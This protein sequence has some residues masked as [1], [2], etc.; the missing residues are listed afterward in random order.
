MV[1]RAGGFSV[2]HSCQRA[3]VAV[4]HS[5]VRYHQAIVLDC[6]GISIVMNGAYVRF[7]S[8]D[9]ASRCMIESCKA[10]VE[11]SSSEPDNPFE[12]RFFRA[13]IYHGAFRSPSHIPL[14]ESRRHAR[15][16][17]CLLRKSRRGTKARWHGAWWRRGKSLGRSIEAGGHESLGSSVSSLGRRRSGR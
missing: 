11:R 16:S 12:L 2:G 14:L 13:E 17:T 4:G 7:L 8:H 1:F 10:C 9:F 5:A 15:R 6:F 3:I